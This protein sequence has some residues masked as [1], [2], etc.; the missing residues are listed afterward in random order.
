[1][2]TK[3]QFLTAVKTD[4]FVRCVKGGGRTL[5]RSVRERSSAMIMPAAE[6]FLDQ[7]GH[8]MFLPLTVV[9]LTG[10]RFVRFVQQQF[11]LAGSWINYATLFQVIGKLLA[12]SKTHKVSSGNAR[13]AFTGLVGAQSDERTFFPMPATHEHEQCHFD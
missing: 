9:L 12:A 2:P 5:A 7:S 8:F 11:N 1:M 6:H 4:D 3:G 13:N 10:V